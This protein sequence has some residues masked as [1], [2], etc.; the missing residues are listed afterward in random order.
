MLGHGERSR[1]QVLL[2]LAGAEIMP[3]LAVNSWAV[4]GA[5]PLYVESKSILYTHYGVKK[6][7]C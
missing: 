3:I 6:V 2:K 7:S 1:S 4:D 5:L